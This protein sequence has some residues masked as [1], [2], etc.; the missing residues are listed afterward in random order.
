VINPDGPVGRRRRL[1]ARQRRL[2]RANRLL[3]GKI[4]E[5]T[6]GQLQVLHELRTPLNAIIGFSE[7]LRDGVFGGLDGAQRTQV[8][9]IHAAGVQMQ[10]VTEDLMELGRADAGV[11][12][13]TYAPVQLGR[14]AESAVSLMRLRAAS[15]GVALR[16]EVGAESA[17]VW[18]D[19]ARLQQVLSNLIGNALKFTPSGG[20][21]VVRV[22]SSPGTPGMVELSVTDSGMGIAPSDQERIFRP[23]EQVDSAI[24]RRSGGAGLGLAIVRRIVALHHGQVRV[25]SAL[26]RG[27]RFSCNFPA[28]NEVL[29]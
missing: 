7:L 16:V 20:L 27:S 23:F 10:R 24:N 2:E 4:R 15:V 1:G 22:D 8:E 5:V 21:V 26:G 25:E 3:S 19:E 9:V 18:G 17:H 13:M 12:R 6:E 14:T 28:L 29:G 11:M